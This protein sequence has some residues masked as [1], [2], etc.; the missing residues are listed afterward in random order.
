VASCNTPKD[1]PEHT[2]ASLFTTGTLDKFNENDEMRVFYEAFKG[3]PKAYLNL[4]DAYH[5]EVQ[6]GMRLN[7][8]SAQFLSCHVGANKGDCDIIYGSGPDSVC[9]VN[10]YKH[11]MVTP[12]DN[13]T[14]V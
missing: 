13:A 7:V 6:E 8:L 1:Q 10:D 11:C 2:V 5:M 14:V 12:A 4:Q 3:K 9:K